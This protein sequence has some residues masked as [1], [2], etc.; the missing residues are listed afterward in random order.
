MKVN[1]LKDVVAAEDG[2]VELQATA[3]YIVDQWG[4]SRR[5]FPLQ[6]RTDF[7]GFCLISVGE[8]LQGAV[9][10]VCDGMAQGQVARHS[11]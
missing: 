4:A 11:L 8:T 5:E 1:R 9:C 3:S 2:L 10:G 7:D 6:I